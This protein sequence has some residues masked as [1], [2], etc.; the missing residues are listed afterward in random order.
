MGFDRV[1]WAAFS[2]GMLLAGCQ[3]PLPTDSEP[4]SPPARPAVAGSGPMLD[5]ERGVLTLAPLLADV[6]PGV[7]NIAVR[8]RMERQT[9][10]LLDDPLFRRYFGLPEDQPELH[11]VSAGS[12]VIVDAGHSYV[13]TNSHV[14]ANAEEIQVTLKD[15]RT[16]P[17]RLVGSDPAT[18]IALLAL[19][20]PDLHAVPL[21]DS[22]QLQVGD[23]VVAIGNPFGL[24][25]TVTS[26]I[27][28]ALGRSGLGIEGYEDFIQTDASIN[29]GNSGGA[30][31]NS[32]GELVGINTAILGASGGN[33]GIGFA[34]PV[35]MASA[36]MAQL[37]EHGEVRRGRLGITIQDLT[38]ALAETMG[39][40]LSTGALVS[41][42][43]ADSAAARAGIQVGDVII[44]INGNAILDADDLRNMI[45]LMPVGT[46]LSIVLYRDGHQRTLDARVDL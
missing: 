5:A 26:G 32:R 20:A 41:Q 34:V 4:R 9:N 10:P 18:D 46:A 22:G 1:V 12:G 24:G 2:A 42:V 35:N 38:P 33:V 14:V 36:V 3:L 25:Q 15:R 27:V 8:S 30:L 21:G 31:V 37:I 40:A 29:P 19:D 6:T 44:E 28:S 23:V 11:V 7:V 13:L 16:Y 39:L 45:G 43:A 17:A